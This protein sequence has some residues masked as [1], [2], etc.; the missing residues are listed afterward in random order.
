MDSS[1]PGE[2]IV[3][4]GLSGLFKISRL[5]PAC[6]NG[7]CPLLWGHS[8]SL[9]ISPPALSLSRAY[10]KSL[11]GPY[12]YLRPYSSSSS[13]EPIQNLLGGPYLY[14][15]PHYSRSSR[16]YSKSKAFLPIS[17]QPLPIS[18]ATLSRSSRAYSKSLGG[19]Y[20]SHTA[21]PGTLKSLF[22]ISVFLYLRPHY[23]APMSLFKI[24]GRPLPIST[25]TLSRSSRAYSKSP[26]GP[27]L[28]L[29]PHYHAPM[30]LFKISRRPLPISTAT[31]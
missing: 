29:R 31:P 3:F 14:L 7:Y 21:T 25:A 28:Y 18:T 15:R 17:T 11:G 6:L 9:G 19:P 8:K 27:Y 20:L 22:K 16:A 1:I 5:A 4:K 26:G 10:S 2:T 24:S 12:L 13:R 30:S 23:H